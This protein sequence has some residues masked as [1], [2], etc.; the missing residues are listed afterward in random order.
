MEKFD[1]VWTYIE[2]RLTPIITKAVRSAL[3]EQPELDPDL[4]SREKVISEYDISNGSLYNLIN[5]GDLTKH[6]MGRLTYFSKTEIEALAKAKKL[7]VRM[8]NKR[9]A[10]K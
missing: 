8:T 6:K 9:R 4:M 2:A 3:P 5:S 7:A 10:E 1:Q